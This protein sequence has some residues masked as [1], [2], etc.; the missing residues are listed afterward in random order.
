MLK[1]DN[2]Y[3]FIRCVVDGSIV[4]SNR[5]RADLFLELKEKGFTPF[6]KKKN[7][8][9]VAVAGATD[10]T[11]EGE[12]NNEVEIAKGVSASDYD[13]L[14][15]LAIG[16]LTAE[17]LQELKN[18]RDKLM[19]EVEELKRATVKSLW[20]KDLDALESKLLEVQ[21]KNE[22]KLEEERLRIHGEAKITRPVQR[23]PRKNSKK[24][25]NKESVVDQME[26]SDNS[27]AETDKAA[28]IKKP[29]GRSAAKKKAPVEKVSAAAEQDED[30]GIAELR[31][32]IAAYNFDSSPDRP[33]E[34]ETE[35]PQ[36]QKNKEPSR[37]AAPRKKQSS[38]VS[39][40]DDIE[41]ID[42]DEDFEP[43]EKKKKGGRKPANG[44]GAAAAKPPT[45]AKKRGPASKQSQLLNQKLI[46]EVLQPAENS[47]EKKV[48]KM[49]ASPFNKKSSSVLGRVINVDEEEETSAEQDNSLSTSGSVT[50]AVVAPKA[51][52]QRARRQA[53]YVISDDSESD[54]ADDDDDVDSDAEDDIDFNDDED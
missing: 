48:R 1:C 27:V 4:V 36:M 47:P 13:Y 15:S 29:K 52:P 23:N 2:K 30:D 5:K 38:T 32:R 44:K 28:E 31:D 16:T 39:D 34:M 53:S 8:A 54:V 26:V 51:R 25:S 18:E 33:E 19:Q 20:L 3:R 21:T 50:E 35:L 49:R 43:E 9:E 41:I 7:A 46:T 42:N 12:E 22:K 24:A 37:T 17:K 6:P 40:D 45:G 11:E 14:L 10:D